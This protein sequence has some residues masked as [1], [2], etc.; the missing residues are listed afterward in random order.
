MHKG[1]IK[2]SISVFLAVTITLILSFCMVLIESARENTLLLKADIVFDAGVQ[3]LLAE[4]HTSLWEEY[5]LFYV[6]CS[7]GTANPSYSLVKAHLEDYIAKNLEYGNRG[8]LALDYDGAIVSDILLATD[9]E[10]KDF[11]LQAVQSA[12]A[13]VGIPYIEQVMTWFEEVEATYSIGDFLQ[14]E[15]EEAGAE[16]ENVNGMEVEV[17]EAVW[18]EDAEGRPIIFEEA[19]Y[20][21][22]DI[23]NPLEQILSG[24]ILLQ[25]VAANNGDISRVSVAI[26]KLASHRNL[27]AGTVEDTR[28]EDSLWNKV[29][30]GKYAMDHF[31]CYGDE[32]DKN[33]SGLQYELEYLIGGKSSDNQNME[34][35]VA[36]LLLIRE[37]DNYLLLLQDEVKKLEAHEIAAA[38]SAALVPWLE[39]VVYQAMLLF[40]AYEESVQDLQ[41]LFRGE[42]IPLIKTLPEDISAELTLGYEEY[43]L[44]LVLLQK[45]EKLAMRSIDIIE[46][47]LRDSEVD[48]CMDACVSRAQLTGV[49]YDTYEKQYT[50]SGKFQYY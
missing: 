48:F 19:E 16:I 3:S 30:F 8:W 12:E 10:G 38:A 43:L 15:M 11:Y 49:F 17:K 5:D 18:G 46:L 25:Q 33:A 7:Y 36:E 50:V 4:F 9:F 26:D 47:S 6:D 39:P 31:S 13:S 27:A 29:L 21:T 22:V 14:K 41:A 44:L 2:G 37:I 24:N 23:E 28:D 45:Q 35:V 42:K 40:W 1:H 34:V 20:E 32:V